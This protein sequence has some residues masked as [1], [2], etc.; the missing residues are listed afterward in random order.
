MKTTNW[1]IPIEDDFN[2]DDCD[3]LITTY[4]N[5]YQTDIQPVREAYHQLYRNWT[6]TGAKLN[7]WKLW[8]DQYHYMSEAMFKLQRYMMSIKN[9]K[10]AQ[11]DGICITPK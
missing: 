4:F 5:T 2:A 6:K 10:V 7:R 11:L 8:T 9:D 1:L 3:E